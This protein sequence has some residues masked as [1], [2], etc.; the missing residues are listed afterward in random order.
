MQK[1]FYNARFLTMNDKLKN[2]EA[3]LVNDD[4]IVF[5]GEKEEVLQLKTDET[6]LIDLNE[7][8]VMPTFF[9]VCSEVY[10]EMEKR[11]KTANNDKFIEKTADND[12][13]YEKFDNFKTYKQEFLNIQNELLKLG[14][15]T[16]QERISSKEEFVFWK[17][18]S[19]DGA[20]KID[21]IGYIDFVKNKQIMDDNC[22]SYRKYKNHFRLGGYHI[23]LDGLLLNR[24]ACLSK[25]YPKEKNY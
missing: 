15:T 12:E 14:I 2:A 4:A 23:S 17:K 3:M 13:N 21:V 9:D 25:K 16:I 8:I 10:L 7:K 6:K 24:K 5:I 20:L 18:I 22:R 11:I 19:E 1:I